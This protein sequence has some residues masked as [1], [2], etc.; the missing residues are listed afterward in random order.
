[1]KEESRVRQDAG[2]WLRLLGFA[3]IP[4]TVQALQPSVG[5][6]LS[7][8]TPLPLAYGMTRRGILEGTAAVAFVALLTALVA[9]SDQGFFFLIETIPLCIGIRWAALARAPLA[10]S[11]ITAVGLVVLTALV[12]VMVYSLLSGQ[13]PVEIY[14]E[15]VQR[16]GIFMDDISEPS[17]LGQEEMPVSYTHLTLPTILLV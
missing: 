14:T 3:L 17:G 2:L 13:G 1:M 9:G 15:T 4:I 5:G 12:S 8:L 16:M 10:R 6:L 7:I 11:I